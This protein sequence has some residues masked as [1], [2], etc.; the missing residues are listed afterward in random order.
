MNIIFTGEIS[1]HEAFFFLN[2]LHFKESENEN[3]RVASLNVDQFSLQTL[4]RLL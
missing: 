1:P 4:P 2:G 3:G